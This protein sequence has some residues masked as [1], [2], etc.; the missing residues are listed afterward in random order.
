L[1]RIVWLEHEDLDTREKIVSIQQLSRKLKR[2]LR[3]NRKIAFT[4]GCFDILHFGHVRYLEKAKRPGRVLIVG[5]N[6]DLSVFRIKGP[7]RP[8]NHERKRAGILAAL[9]CVDYVVIFSE[10]TPYRLIQSIRPDV[11]IKGADWKGK[12]IVGEDIVRANGGRIELIP[13]IRGLSTTYLINRIRQ[14][15]KK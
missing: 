1:L 11:L 13:Y 7:G 15:E 3:E 4:N 6:S 12:E 8:V 5:L 2:H 9:A 14:G 10:D